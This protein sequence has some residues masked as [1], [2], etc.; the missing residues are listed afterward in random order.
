M[1]L[2]P[3][4]PGVRQASTSLA[5]EYGKGAGLFWTQGVLWACA[6]K[7]GVWNVLKKYGPHGELFFFLTKK[8]PSGLAKA[9]ESR[10]C[11]A[12]ETGYVL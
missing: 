4:A 8:E 6:Q 2:G 11:V 9:V 7:P 3:R 5:R 1:T 12:A 10:A